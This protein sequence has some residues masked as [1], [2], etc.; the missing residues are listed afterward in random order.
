MH[1]G[2]NL[3][4]TIT[5]L[6]SVEYCEPTNEAEQL[7]ELRDYVFNIINSKGEYKSLPKSKGGYL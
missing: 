3:D 6:I 7:I 4:E 2:E 1:I 5:Q